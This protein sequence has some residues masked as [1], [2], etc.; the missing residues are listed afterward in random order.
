MALCARSESP[1][2]VN[3]LPHLRKNIDKNNCRLFGPV[4]LVVQLLMGVFVLG[5]LAY[6][7]QKERPRRPWHIW[8]LDVSKQLAGQLVVHFLNVLMSA[9]Q[10]VN[11]GGNPCSLYFLNILLDS[12][13]GVCFLYYLMR[14]LLH[15]FQVKLRVRGL[16]S[17]N[18]SCARHTQEEALP[19]WQCWLRQTG[20]YVLALSLMKLVVLALIAILPVLILFGNWILSLF[21]DQRAWQ[22]VFSM[23]IFPLAMNTLQFWLIDSMLL[24]NPEHSSYSHLHDDPTLPL[25]H[26]T[27]D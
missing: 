14:I 13:L 18:Y 9:A 3:V 22:V 11:G 19:E 6:K 5:S 27:S 21:G 12:T 26:D 7:R 2:E 20:V 23:A 17:G 25:E 16:E 1:I 10:T 15:V 24:Y 8:V 4:A